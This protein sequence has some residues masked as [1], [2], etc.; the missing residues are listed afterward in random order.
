M[1]RAE[2]FSKGTQQLALVRQ[3]FRCASCGTRVS[4]LG[5]PGRVQHTYGEIAHAHHVRHIKRG[6]TNSLENCVI[7]CQACHYSAHEG[8]NYR[9][10][11][12][13]GRREDFPHFNG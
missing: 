2:E 3:K 1:S 4:R 12:V 10:G 8:G 13:L 11:T 7:I 5:E 6:G 9:H